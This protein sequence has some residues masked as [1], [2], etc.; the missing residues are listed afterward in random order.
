MSDNCCDH[1][2]PATMQPIA[3]YLVVAMGEP[4][5]GTD[6]M[7]TPYGIDLFTEFG[8]GNTY[9]KIVAESFAVVDFETTMTKEKFQKMKEEKVI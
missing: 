9:T 8:D 6:Y 7:E 5:W 3:R 4:Y 2:D 1:I